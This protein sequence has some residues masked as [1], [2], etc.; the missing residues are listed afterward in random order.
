MV[1]P[2]TRKAAPHAGA[3]DSEPALFW[4]NRPRKPIYFYRSLDLSIHSDHAC[5]RV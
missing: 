1:L 5:Y 2:E 4:G 3:F